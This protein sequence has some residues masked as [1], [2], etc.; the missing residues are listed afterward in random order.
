MSRLKI[1]VL[2]ALAW[3]PLPAAAEVYLLMAEEEGCYWCEKWNEEIGPIYPK[4]SEGQTAPLRRYDLHGTAPKGVRFSAAVHYTPTFVLVQD[5]AEVGRIEGYPGDEF[6]WG[7]LS[8]LL[9]NARIT[10]DEAG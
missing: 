5:G 8:K 9:E 7:L 3:L 1:L 2:L 10:R 6:F 4:T